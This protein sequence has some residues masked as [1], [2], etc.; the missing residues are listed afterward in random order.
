MIAA[1]GPASAP[2]S[3]IELH[4]D[5]AGLEILLSRVKQLFPL[6]HEEQQGLPRCRKYEDNL[7]DLHLSTRTGIASCHDGVEH[8]LCAILEQDVCKA[9]SSG[10]L[11]EPGSAVRR[12]EECYL[13]GPTRSA[14]RAEDQDERAHRVV[15]VIMEP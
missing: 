12:L 14:Q 4:I 15:W 9:E 11:A 1:L 2:P 3:A 6:R 10:I 8:N 7:H 13:E 5:F